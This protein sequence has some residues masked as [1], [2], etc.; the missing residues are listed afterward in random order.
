M[1]YMTKLRTNIYLDRRQ[2]V[3]LDKLS[4]KTGA[5]VAALIRRAIDAYLRSRGKG[6]KS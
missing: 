6:F 3:R 5:P 4:A 2:K 1:V